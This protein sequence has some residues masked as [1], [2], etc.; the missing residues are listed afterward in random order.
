MEQPP[1]NLRSIWGSHTLVRS[2]SS[3]SSYVGGSLVLE[4]KAGGSYWESNDNQLIS[5]HRR[6]SKGQPILGDGEVLV[7]GRVSAHERLWRILK[8]PS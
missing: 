5:N 1:R 4:K 3:G 7:G 8:R 6:Y 2:S